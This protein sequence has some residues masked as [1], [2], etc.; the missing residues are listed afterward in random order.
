MN[1]ELEQALSHYCL[2]QVAAAQRVEKGFANE[3]WKLTTDEGRFFLKRREARPGYHQFIHA[4]HRLV[5]HLHRVGFPAPKIVSTTEGHLLLE[6]GGSWYE[7]QDYIDGGPYDHDRPTHL[8]EAAI[9]LGRY[10]RDVLGF[11]PGILRSRGDL[12]TPPVINGH[13]TKLTDWWGT[14]REAERAETVRRVDAKIDDLAA[15]FAA[16][17][18]LRQLVIHGDYYAGNLIFKGDRIVGVVDYD[19]ARWH[20]RIAELAEA[21]IYFSSPR[22]TYVKRIVYPGVLSWEPFSLFLEG[23]CQVQSLD[24]KEMQALPDYVEAIW[25]SM[26][27]R[28]LWERESHPD[29]AIEALG[30]VLSLVDWA[31]ANASQMTEAARAASLE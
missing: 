24:S 22:T 31:S 5:E 21:L 27:L 13:L 9:T 18:A 10:H 11:A 17:G 19:K 20:P 7:I 6:I 1:A 3:H 23:Y 26:S 2:G 4:Q 29:H 12:Y 28:R 8:T 30:E 14:E 15:R 25:L 16:H